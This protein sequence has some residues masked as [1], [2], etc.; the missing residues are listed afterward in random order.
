ME[1]NKK[2][3]RKRKSWSLKEVINEWH[4]SYKAL[5]EK[6]DSLI[7]D[8]WK[9]KSKHKWLNGSFVSIQSL[10]GYRY[11]GE[12]HEGGHAKQ[13]KEYFKIKD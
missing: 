11:L 1:F 7:K 12:G 10:Y 2:E 13:I 8:E 5:L 6:I 4:N 3:I 9:Y